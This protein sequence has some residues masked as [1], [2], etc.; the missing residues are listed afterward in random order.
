[1]IIW[2]LQIGSFNLPTFIPHLEFL[3]RY[4]WTIDPQLVNELWSAVYPGMVDK[5]T[6]RSVQCTV[7]IWDI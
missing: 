3:E 1:M 6:G 4:W 5:A 7:F 2:S